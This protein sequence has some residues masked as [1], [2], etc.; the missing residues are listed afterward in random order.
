MEKER[1]AH[2]YTQDQQEIRRDR[3]NGY[4]LEERGLQKEAYNDRKEKNN[5][6]LHYSVPS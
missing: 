5:L 4:F 6:T 1:N 3:A 2:R